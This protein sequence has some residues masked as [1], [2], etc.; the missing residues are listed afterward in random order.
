MPAGS[1]LSSADILQYATEELRSYITAFLKGIREEFIITTLD[2]SVASGTVAAPRRAV[3]A[4][5][6]TIGWML[7]DGRERP[8]PRIEPESAGAYEGQTGG[9]VG[10]MFQGN[11]Y[12]LLPA[13][14]TG[15]IR[16]RYQQRP[17]QLVATSACAE[18]TAINTGTKTLTFAAAPTAFS[19][20]ETFDIVSASAN[21]TALGIDLAA[22]GLTSTTL[23]L[24]AAVP[25]GVA[26]GDWICLA[27]ETCIPQVPTEVFDLLAQ[28][29]A[30]KIAQA[31]G[32][33]RLPGIKAGLD[34]L[35]EQM[36]QILSPRSDGSA[37][38]IVNRSFIGRWNMGW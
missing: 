24:T 4:A 11:S 19:T 18:I 23:V 20:S 38:V 37:R 29:T 35:R 13:P 16:L 9:P 14:T 6:R 12:I 28:A 21:F 1:G 2:V 34:D 10:Y 22:T 30:H 5:L 25:T 7:S 27:G 8:L 15:T 17:G 33:A 26:V 36:T 3:G 32:S 31:Q